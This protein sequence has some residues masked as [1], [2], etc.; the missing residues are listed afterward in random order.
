MLNVGCWQGERG[1]SV[2]NV[3]K[4]IGIRLNK[5]DIVK[6][7]RVDD[8]EMFFLSL[9]LYV[10]LLNPPPPPSPKQ[11]YILSHLKIKLYFTHIDGTC[12]IEGGWH[13]IIIRMSLWLLQ[14]SLYIEWMTAL[15]TDISNTSHCFI[16]FGLENWDKH[17]LKVTIIEGSLIDVWIFLRLK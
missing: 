11:F 15:S 16:L 7:K 13:T 5:V 9:P 4:I 2:E 14:F 1:A 6:K 10:L 8:D 12:G 17:K 3:R